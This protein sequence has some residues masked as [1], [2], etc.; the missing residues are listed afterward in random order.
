MLCFLFLQSY[1]P[2]GAKHW[3]GFP[4]RVVACAPVEAV[5]L[6]ETEQVSIYA[7]T[8]SHIVAEEVEEQIWQNRWNR[9]GGEAHRIRGRR[10]ARP[11]ES[12]PDD[13]AA[14]PSSSSAVFMNRALAA[15]CR[16]GIERD[17][18]AYITKIYRLYVWMSE[19]FAENHCCRMCKA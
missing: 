6:L 10:I 5:L 19:A 1:H 9:M 17:D 12:R 2:L 18:P 7:L 11:Y 14:T 4:G 8:P 13:D 3:A 16:W 15:V